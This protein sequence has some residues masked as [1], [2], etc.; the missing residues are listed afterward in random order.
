MNNYKKLRYEQY[1]ID[2]SGDINNTGKASF[3][4]EYKSINYVYNG[5]LT[6]ANYFIR[7]DEKRNVIQIHFEGTKDI[8]DWFTNILFQPK[9]YESF[10]CDGKKITLKVHKAWSAMYKVMKTF[11]RDEVS[12]LLN[13]HK[14]PEIEI[15]GWSLGSAMATLCAQDLNYNLGIKSHL[16]TFGSVNLFKTNIFNRRRTIKYL[17]NTTYEY[18]IICNRNDMV[19]YLVPRLFG[20]VKIGRVNTKKKFNFFGLFNIAKN[21][22]NYDDERL[23]RNIY[24]KEHIIKK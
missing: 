15:I 23:Y 24:K 17:R 22:F 8:P 11:I 6:H 10:I 4:I 9:Y 3:K 14:E 18:H 16:F 21:H 2:T 13:E 19:S 12:K 20:F 1:F 5:I 7:Y